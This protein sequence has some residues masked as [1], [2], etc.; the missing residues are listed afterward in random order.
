MYNAMG[1]SV[2]IGDA[3]EKIQ[4]KIFTQFKCFLPGSQIWVWR[5]LGPTKERRK[6]VPLGPT[7]Y[8][9]AK[10]CARHNEDCLRAVESRLGLG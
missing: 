1:Q 7:A 8:R 3:Q 4:F 2:T 5:A 10:F 9:Q 6:S